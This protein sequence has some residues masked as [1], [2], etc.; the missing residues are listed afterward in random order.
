M[1]ILLLSDTHGLLDKVYEI[2]GKLNHIDLIIHCGDYQRDA[3]TL[4]DTLGIP[5]VSVK[6]NCDG[7]SRPDRE[8]V[9]TPAGKLLITH[10]H[11]EGAGYDYNNL[12]YLAEEKDCIAVCFGHTHVPMCEDFGGIYL[13][14]PGSLTNPRDGSQRF[15]R[16]SPQHRRG[17]FMPTS[18][19][20]IPSAAVR[21]RKSPREASS[22][23]CSTTA[24]G[25]KYETWTCYDLAGPFSLVFRISL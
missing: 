18:S 24:T 1:K 21:K 6:G 13:I 8:I 3:H 17:I 15:L 23:G 11:L 20:T 9:E 25:F 16:H 5:I 12:L 19:T 7:A 4:E 22:G 10:G 2:Y 14:N